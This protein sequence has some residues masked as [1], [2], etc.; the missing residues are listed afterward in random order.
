MVGLTRTCWCINTSGRFSAASS[1]SSLT[2]A[3]PTLSDTALCGAAK[4]N[5][6]GDDAAIW[7]FDA[8]WVGRNLNLIVDWYLTPCRLTGTTA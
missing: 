7:L 8:S 5:H 4:R 6:F 1:G 3:F 2:Q